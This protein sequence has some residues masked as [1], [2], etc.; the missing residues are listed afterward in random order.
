MPRREDYPRSVA[1]S[2]II[3]GLGPTDAL[4]SFRQAGGRI[5]TESWYRLYGQERAGF[6]A[7]IREQTLPTNRRPASNE[8]QRYSSRTATGYMQQVELTVR[9]RRSHLTL[10]KRFTYRTDTLVTRNRAVTAA[11]DTYAGASDA[12]EEDILGAAYTGTFELFP[13]A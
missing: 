10:T 4:T 1:R 2:A 3:A 8:V 13:E 9:D 6:G 12:Y 5:R 11:I 7:K